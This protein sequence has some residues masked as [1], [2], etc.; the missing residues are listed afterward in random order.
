MHEA[1]AFFSNP[2]SINHR[3]Y[4]A[5]RSIFMDGLSSEDAAKKFGYTLYTMKSLRR[6]FLNSLKHPEDIGFQFFAEPAAG[7]PSLESRSELVSEIVALRKQNHSILDIK[8]IFHAKGHELSHGYIHKVL[9]KDG[10]AKLLKRSAIERNELT[11]KL[12]EAPASRPIDW[13]EDLNKE[14]YSERSIGLLAF[15]PLMAQLAWI[16]T[17]QN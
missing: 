6:D 9:Q 15:L 2:S 1:V 12:I 4:E 3:R 7:R 10:F 8:S 14:F 16:S 5:L 11:A 17:H 13:D